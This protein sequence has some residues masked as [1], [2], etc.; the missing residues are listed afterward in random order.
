VAAHREKGGF[1]V[2]TTRPGVRWGIVVLLTAIATLDAATATAQSCTSAAPGNDCIP[3][4]GGKG[5]DC[6]LELLTNPAPVRKKKTGIPTTSLICYEGDPTCDADGDFTNNSCSI[7]TTLCINNTDLRLPC[8]PTNLNTVEIRKPNPNS[9]DPSD[10]ANIGQLEAR[11]GGGGFGLTVARHG[12]IVQTGSS[13][14]TPN[15]CSAPMLLEV[16]LRQTR[17]GKLKAHSTTFKLSAASAFGVLDTDGLRIQCR[18]STCGNHKIE[19]PRETCDDGNRNDGDGCDHS[20]RIEPAT[21]TQTRT[22]TPTP[23]PYTCPAG[24]SCGVFEVQPGFSVSKPIDD[25]VTSWVELTDVSGLNLI[26]NGTSGAFNQGPVIVKKQGGDANGIA[27][28][29]LSETVYVGAPLPLVAQS[30]GEKGKVCFKMQADPDDIGWV[31]CNGGSNAEVAIS[32]DSHGTSADDPP[33][34]SV[35]GGATDSGPG[36]AVVR[37]LYQFGRT[38]DDNTLCSDADFSSSPLLKTALTTASATSTVFNVRQHTFDPLGYPDA[39]TSITLSGRPFDC[40]TWGQVVTPS[41]SLVVP[42]FALNYDAPILQPNVDI[43]ITT[44]LQLLVQ[45][46]ST[47]TPT[48][49]LGPTHSPTETPTETPTLAATPT[50]TPSLTPTAIPTHTVTPTPSVTPT[51][52]PTNTP[53]RTATPSVTQTPTQTPTITITPTGTVPATD[54]PTVTPTP[55]QTGT[56]T[57]TFTPTWTSTA[58]PTNTP[59]RTGTATA[60]ATNTRT[61]LGTLNLTVATGSNSLCPADSAAG[62]FLK[63]RGSPT[64]S[65]FVGEVCS[66][67]RGNFTSGP[68]VLTGGAPDASGV[69]TLSIASAVVIDGQQPSQASDDHVCWRLEANG[70]G[71]I[72]CDGGMNADATVTVASN[73]TS[74]PPAPAWS[75]TWLAA[76]SGAGNTG[77]GAAIIPVSVKIQS[78][79]STCPGAADASWNSIVAH[80]TVA[81]TGTATVTINS[82]RKCPGG[83]STTGT[84]PNSPYVAALSGTNFNCSN[85]TTNSGARIVIPNAELD[86]DFGSGGGATFGVGDLAEVARYND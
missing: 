66:A 36:A 61:P 8:A 29:A 77:A 51:F 25:G 21:P 19:S 17:T 54:T 83:N 1:G 12:I 65:I 47:R 64:G 73:T 5:T 15:L 46:A 55:T 75:N 3:G 13:N 63:I 60:T 81:V 58:T 22:P 70:A 2:I 57:A 28:L 79:T 24:F 31:D 30:L 84:C 68:I 78:T 38:T 59:T 41:A 52:T 33:Q 34:L 7:N 20:C 56:S 18:P 44:R 80:T 43:A 50:F 32:V 86:V 11:L 40:A 85:W 48:P 82:A 23:T 4:G 35:G 16:R 42:A 6:Y 45:G 26:N 62:S 72:D 39:D 14:A 37:V 67:T 53:T 27:S 74:A 49:T 71:S 10:A 76:P 9:L 69:A